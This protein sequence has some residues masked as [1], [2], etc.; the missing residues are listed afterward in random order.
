[1]GM[2]FSEQTG[3][4]LEDVFQKPE[5]LAAGIEMIEEMRADKSI[6]SLA[7]DAEQMMSMSSDGPNIDDNLPLAMEHGQGEVVKFINDALTMLRSKDTSV[8]VIL[9]GPEEILRYT[10]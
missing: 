10:P 8:T 6:G 1:M 3:T 2:T 4:S 9:D 7:A 5:M